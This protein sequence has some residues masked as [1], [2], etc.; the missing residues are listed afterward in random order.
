M[1]EFDDFELE[2][3]SSCNL[4]DYMFHRKKCLSVIIIAQTNF[5]NNTKMLYIMITLKNKNTIGLSPLKY[6]K[7]LIIYV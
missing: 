7:L 3:P 5:E 4:H 6:V 1:L 2:H